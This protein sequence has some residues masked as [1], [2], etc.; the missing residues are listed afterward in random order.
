VVLFGQ[1]TWVILRERFN[2]TRSGSDD[3]AAGLL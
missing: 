3:A 1:Q 2:V